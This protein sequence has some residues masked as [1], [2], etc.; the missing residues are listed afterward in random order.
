MRKLLAELFYWRDG[1]IG[2]G[3]FWVAIAFVAW[4]YI[5]HPHGLRGMIGG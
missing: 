3:W 2:A 1:G 4:L 5:A